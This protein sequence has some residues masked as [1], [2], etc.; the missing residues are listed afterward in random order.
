[1][2]NSVRTLLLALVV[3]FPA[4]AH[5]GAGARVLACIYLAVAPIAT[6]TVTFT[7]GG[8]DTHCMNDTGNNTTFSLTAAGVTCGSVGYVESKSSSSGG[9]TCATDQSIWSLSYSISAANGPTGSTGSVKTEWWHPDLGDNHIAFL[10][11]S[12]GTVVCGAQNL[13]TSTELEWD[14]GTTGPI[15]IIFNPASSA[16]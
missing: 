7:A 12:T 13:C 1:M 2:T 11:Q 10:T 15:Y 14:G 5:A 16:G 3:M 8:S 9:D 6:E 4:V